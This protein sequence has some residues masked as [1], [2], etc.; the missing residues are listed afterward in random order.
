MYFSPKH[1]LAVL[2]V[3]DSPLLTTYFNSTSKA[4]V[5]TLFRIVNHKYLSWVE[6]QLF[7][8]IGLPWRSPMKSFYHLSGNFESYHNFRNIFLHNGQRIIEF[9][10]FFHQGQLKL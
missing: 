6:L 8:S 2:S 5:L 1:F 7:P 9:Q 10:T 3:D 4:Y